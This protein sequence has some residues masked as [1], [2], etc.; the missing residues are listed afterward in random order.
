MRVALIDGDMVVHRCAVVVDTPLER[1]SAGLYR[2]DEEF[3][4][5]NTKSQIQGIAQATDCDT[6]VVAFSSSDN[7]R[8]GVDP[9]YKGHRKNRKPIVLAAV[10]EAITEWSDVSTIVKAG[11]EADDVL[12]ILHTGKLVG[13]S[14]ICSGDK[15]LLTIPGT[16]YNPW[17]EYF[18]GVVEV[19]E[20]EAERRFY[21]QTICGDRVDGYT[22]APGWGDIKTGR[23]LQD[24]EEPSDL[25]QLT[26][27]A[28]DGDEEAAIQ[29]ARLAR[30]LRDGEFNYET[31][32]P[33][34][35]Q[36]PVGE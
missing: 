21:H 25:W 32:K 3:A 7:Y 14:V 11:L 1:V 19:G 9:N 16:H 28:F 24:A 35:W 17:Q 26:L 12:G 4:I 22:G 36:P 23:L 2:F 33:I 20:A 31:G 27:S 8:M 13:K 15:D 10:R 6:I 30:I 18:G 5:Q 34:L 29:N